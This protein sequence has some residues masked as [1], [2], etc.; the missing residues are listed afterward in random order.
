MKQL[1]KLIALFVLFTQ[2][3][4][5]QTEADE[6]AIRGLVQSMADGWTEGSGEKFAAAFADEHD[7][8][9]WNGMYFKNFNTQGNAAAHQG[10][11]ESVYKDTEHYATVDKV[12]FIREDIA[13]IHVLAAVVKK[14][15][16][17]P[18]DPGV[19]WTGLLE[20]QEGQW[21]IISFHNLDL[22]IFQDE[23]MRQR[24][25]MPP[26]VMYASWYAEA[27]R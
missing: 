15:E 1:V 24:A 25:P 9:V 5:S 12:K 4:F 23:Q 10:L 8:I 22:E 27:G 18:A 21:K 13:L 17:R 11:F 19:L 7:Y 16:G 26:Q 14:G 2:P 20:K 3:L 6:A